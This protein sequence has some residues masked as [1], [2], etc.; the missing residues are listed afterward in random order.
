[1]GSQRRVLLPYILYG[2]EIPFLK[3]IHKAMLDLFKLQTHHLPL[4]GG[5]RRS[6]SGTTGCDQALVLLML[7]EPSFPPWICPP[8]RYRGL[9]DS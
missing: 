6:A 8:H 3:C 7:K 9:R 1:M 4:A 2:I 5:T